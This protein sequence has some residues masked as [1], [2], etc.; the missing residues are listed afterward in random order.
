MDND[1]FSIDTLSTK[2]TIMH[3]IHKS[4]TKFAISKAINIISLALQQR[5]SRH[6]IRVGKKF[7]RA[8]VFVPRLWLAAVIF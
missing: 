7:I 3:G 6:Q 2:I 1:E 5:S 8:V 4:P